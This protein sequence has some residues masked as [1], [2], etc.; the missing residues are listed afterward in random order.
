MMSPG[1]I[2]VFMMTGLALFSCKQAPAPE[3]GT[4]ETTLPEKVAEIQTITLR[5]SDFQHEILSNGKLKAGRSVDLSFKSAEVIAQISVKNGDRVEAGQV[6]A[7]LE[8]FKLENNLTEA[9]MK[10]EEAHLLFQD[11]LFGMGYHNPL[12]DS[13]T[14]PQNKMRIAVI[15]SGYENAIIARDLA[16]YELENSVLKTPFAGTVSG[17]FDK[18]YNIAKAGETFCTILDYSHLEVDFSILESELGL[19]KAGDQM[20]VAP[21]AFPERKATGRVTEINPVVDD[22]GMVQIRAEIPYRPDLY[23]G[24]NVKVSVLRSPGMKLVVPKSAVVVRT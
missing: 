4:I 12:Q 8:R 15:Q 3:E 19:V 10:V 23:E 14:I 21:F 22:N 9:S 16:R 17:L 7:E 5:E 18:Q 24:M 1:K 11:K 13:A 2:F 6:L 20:S